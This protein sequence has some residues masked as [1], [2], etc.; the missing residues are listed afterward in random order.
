MF[1]LDLL[2]V[3]RLIGPLL[4][5]LLLDG[6]ARG[7]T[8][9]G[10]GLYGKRGPGHEAFGIGRAAGTADRF[11]TLTNERFEADAAGAAAKI[12]QR[13]RRPPSL[14]TDDRPADAFAA[15]AGA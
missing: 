14:R 13:H 10:A 11:V 12:V 15:M 7:G 3:G 4:T 6:A 8:Q 9:T 2:L 5:L 1:L